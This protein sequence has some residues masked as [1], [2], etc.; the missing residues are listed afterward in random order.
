MIKEQRKIFTG[1]ELRDMERCCALR[2]LLSKPLDRK[3][4]LSANCVDITTHK[5][6]TSQ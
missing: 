4:P 3:T 5:Y 6:N 2:Y 1:A